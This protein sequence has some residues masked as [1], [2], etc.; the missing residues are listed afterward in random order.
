VKRETHRLT[1]AERLTFARLG[2]AYRPNATDLFRFWWT[3][4]RA[5]GL[6]SRTIIGVEN[7][8]TAFTALPWGHGKHWCWPLRLKCRKSAAALE[9]E[10]V[11]LPIRQ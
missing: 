1:P 7:D 11:D 3:V 8:P 5:R 10:Q 4:G 6:D 9:A 2:R